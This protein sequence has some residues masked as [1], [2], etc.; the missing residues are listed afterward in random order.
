MRSSRFARPLNH[1][2]EVPDPLLHLGLGPQALVSRRLP[3]T[4]P[5][6]ASSALK[7]GK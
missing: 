1:F 3:L 7:S 4:R 6:T 5:Q 2:K